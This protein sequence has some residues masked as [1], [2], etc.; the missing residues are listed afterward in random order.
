MF[1]SDWSALGPP[2]GQHAYTFVIRILSKSLI[3]IFSV[4]CY[5][6]VSFSVA[7]TPMEKLAAATPYDFNYGLRQ[8]GSCPFHNL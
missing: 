1:M 4:C 6:R 5:S 3:S 7:E 8:P 2:E